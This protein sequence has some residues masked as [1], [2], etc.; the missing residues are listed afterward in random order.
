MQ[1]CFFGRVN[2]GLAMAWGMTCNYVTLLS[3]L[4]QQGLTLE[5]LCGAAPSGSDMDVCSPGHDR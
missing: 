3:F 2:G 5:L 1:E 4:F